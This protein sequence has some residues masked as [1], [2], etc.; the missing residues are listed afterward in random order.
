MMKVRK[1]AQELERMILARLRDEH[2][3]PAGLEIEVRRVNGHW[4]AFASFGEASFGDE[5]DHAACVAA[6]RYLPPN[7][8]PRSTWR[9]EG[10]RSPGNVRPR[11]RA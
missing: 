9:I 5:G 1:T 10:Y 8:V 3:C 7:C 2:L 4:D 11:C 6:S